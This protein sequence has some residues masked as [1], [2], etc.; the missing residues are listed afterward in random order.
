MV[1]GYEF[2]TNNFAAILDNSSAPEQFHRVQDF[3][4][5]SPIGYALIQPESISTG[6][7]IQIWS[8]TEIEEGT[9]KFTHAEH[10]YV[11]TPDVVREALHLPQVNS[12]APISPDD[13]IKRFIESLGY[14]GDTSKLGKLV[15]A[16]L[17]FYTSNTNYSTDRILSFSK[18]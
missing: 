9:I 12:F 7:V 15:R 18:Y 1:N 2:V 14:S 3:L 5:A 17:M 8:T 6:A 10:E 16:K 11:I 13:E 4:R